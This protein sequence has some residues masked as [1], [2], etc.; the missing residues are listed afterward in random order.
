MSEN[1]IDISGLD[2]ADV[3]VALFNNSRQ[4]G[5]GLLDVS[6]AQPMTKEDA[7][8]IIAKYED[9]QLYFDYVHGRV[10]KVDLTKDEFWPALYDRDNGQGAAAAAINAIR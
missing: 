10:L 7:E 5:L 4:Q 6:G 2:K 3:L 8:K 1:T 9:T